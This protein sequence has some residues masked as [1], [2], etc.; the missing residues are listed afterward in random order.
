MFP[1][2][3]LVQK[4]ELP[5]VIWM[6]LL[7]DP[8]PSPPTPGSESQDWC[9]PDGQRSLWLGGNGEA[10][11]Q[12]KPGLPVL[13]NLKFAILWFGYNEVHLQNS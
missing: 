10:V 4:T 3:C 9:F 7:I 5:Y 1:I 11:D 2:L 8:E 13:M 6:G 12:A